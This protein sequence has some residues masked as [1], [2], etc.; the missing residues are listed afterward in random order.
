[1]EGQEVL[2][3]ELEELVIPQAHHHPKVIMEVLE[4]FQPQTTALAVEVVRHQLALM[5]LQLLEATVE[6]EPHLQFLARR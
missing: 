1:V 5:R 6:M 4:Y 3:I 2:Q